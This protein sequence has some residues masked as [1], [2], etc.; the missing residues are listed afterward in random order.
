MPMP[1]R[2]NAGMPLSLSHLANSWSSED[3]SLT[4]LSSVNL[5]LIPP[6][7]HNP[8]LGPHRPVAHVSLTLEEGHGTAENIQALC[9]KT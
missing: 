1:S 6:S 2:G 3:L 9:Q 4:T 8:S 5:S 7:S